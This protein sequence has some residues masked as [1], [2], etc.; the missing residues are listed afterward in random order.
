MARG[1]SKGPFN[2]CVPRNLILREISCVAP[3]CTDCVPLSSAKLAALFPSRLSLWTPLFG[4]LGVESL[5]KRGLE[6]TLWELRSCCERARFNAPEAPV[7]LARDAQALSSAQREF[8]GLS[9]ELLREE[10]LQSSEGTRIKLQ[11]DSNHR[12]AQTRFVRHIL[13]LSLAPGPPPW[14]TVSCCPSLRL[15]HRMRGFVSYV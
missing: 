10:D 5:A 9:W 14:R 8:R 6:Y 3:K 2:G 7:R 12:C 4:D 1:L 11:R 13:S 15:P